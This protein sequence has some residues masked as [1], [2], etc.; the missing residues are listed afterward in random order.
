MQEVVARK[1]ARF[2]TTLRPLFPGYMFVKANSE[3]APWSAINS[4]IGVS[5]LVTVG[6]KPRPLP[7]KLVSN[8]M[9]RCDQTGKMRSLRHL[10]EGDRVELTT[11]P[12]AQFLATVEKVEPD[13]RIW[14]LIELMGQTSRMQVP[15]DQLRRKI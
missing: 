9:L 12:F 4:T 7:P 15:A 13:K 3:A 5:K 10:T 8:L 11:G 6:G 1:A 2:V 14:V